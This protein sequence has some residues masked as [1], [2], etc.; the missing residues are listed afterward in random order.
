[1]TRLSGQLVPHPATPCAAVDAIEVEV[2][3]VGARLALHYR[4]SG[5]P[6]ALVLPP[7]AAAVRTDELW[8]HTCFEAFVRPQPGEAY[9]EVNLAPSGQWAA[10]AFDGYRAG[11]RPAEV[12]EPGVLFARTADG[13][14]L[15]AALDLA[16]AAPWRLGVTAVI[17]EAGGRISYW[18]LAHP[19]GK[20]DFHSPDCLALELPAPEGA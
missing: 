15:E 11:M 2:E 17:E 6:E 13:L 16:D 12:G 3:R 9:L 4:L 20:P 1:M 14:R 18:A 5:R 19:P 10:Y 7:P 8:R